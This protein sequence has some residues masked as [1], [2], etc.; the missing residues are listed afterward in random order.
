MPDD[1]TKTRPQDAQRVNLQEPYELR[2]WCRKFGCSEEQ[3]KQAVDAVGVMAT[4]VEA[5]LKKDT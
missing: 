2:A 1:K 4:D 5:W 3:L